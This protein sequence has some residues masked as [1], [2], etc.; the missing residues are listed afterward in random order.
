MVVVPEPPEVVIQTLQRLAELRP[1]DA[2]RLER[3]FPDPRR[4]QRGVAAPVAQRI[5]ADRQRRHQ[6][7]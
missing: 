1:Q 2:E 3:R 6:N 4:E 5:E 7:E